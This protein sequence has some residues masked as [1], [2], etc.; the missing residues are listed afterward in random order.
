MRS[1]GLSFRFV[2][3]CLASVP[4]TGCGAVGEP[5][6]GAPGH[7]REYGYANLSGRSGT[8]PFEFLL[9]RTRLALGREERGAAPVL[10]PAAAAAAWDETGEADAVQWLGHGTVRVR[11][12][13]NEF[14]VD[15][16]FAARTSPVS[17]IGPPRASPPPLGPADLAGAAAVLITHDHYDHL[18]P[19]SLAPIAAA[20]AICLVPLGVSETAPAG[21]PTTQLDWHQGVAIG[22]ATATLLPAQHE[23]GRGLFDRDASLWGAWLIEGDGAR[24]YLSGDTG[25]GDH[26]AKLGAEGGVDLAVLIVGGYRPRAFNRDVHMSPE[27]AVA[28][29]LDLRAERALIVGWGTYPLGLETGHETV[30]RLREAAAAAGLAPDRILILPIGGALRL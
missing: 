12:S 28:A 25:Y 27:E 26:F 1:S 13:G 5:V 21:C 19:R 6:P 2:V 7:H 24:V 20:G 22:P 10:A 3:A 14:L 30:R 15:P 9:D 17:S 18:E 8:D 23:S 11:I 4:L 16:V 29:I